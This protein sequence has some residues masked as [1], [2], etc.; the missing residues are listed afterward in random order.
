MKICE[1]IEGCGDEVD[2]TASHLFIPV[3]FQ[4]TDAS[5][6]ILV[7]EMLAFR[8]QPSFF[9]NLFFFSLELTY[10]TL[11]AAFAFECFVHSLLSCLVTQ[12]FLLPQTTA[13]WRAYCSCVLCL[14]AWHIH[15]AI[16]QLGFACRNSS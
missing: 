3:S 1:L 15:S 2:G 4:M 9:F 14:S 6:R 10:I 8:Y 5:D 11:T 16:K 13:V 12:I 7:Q